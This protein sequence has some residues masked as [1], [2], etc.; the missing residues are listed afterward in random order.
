MARRKIEVSKVE[1]AGV[2]GDIESEQVFS[3]RN[4]LAN[5]VSAKMDIS[6][7][8]VLLRIKEFG[9]QPKTP[10]G[11]RG[12]Q[13]G[14]KL[15]KDQK[16]AMQ[17]GRSKKKNFDVSAMR[18]NFPASYKGLLDKV[19]A[20]SYA[21]TVKGKCLDCVQ[22]QKSE[23]TNCTCVSCPLWHVRPYQKKK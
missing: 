20:G 2:I 6:P 1:L 14:V 10:K 21:A 17:A 16:R 11:K 12:R 15:S 9:L 4:D 3:T 18:K 5:A 13:P 8:I 23:I 7:S 22:F 19:S